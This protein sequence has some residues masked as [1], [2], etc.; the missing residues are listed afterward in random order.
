MNEMYIHEKYIEENLIEE[1]FKKAIEMADVNVEMK[2]N[3]EEPSKNIRIIYPCYSDKTKRISEQEIKQL[4]IQTLIEDQKLNEDSE[5]DFYFSVETPTEFKYKFSNSDGPRVYNEKTDRNNIRRF[6]SARFDLCMHQIEQKK[7]IRK[8]LLEFKATNQETNFQT[9]FLKLFIEKIE[10]K[11]SCNYFIHILDSADTGTLKEA[12]NKNEKSVIQK[13]Y[14]SWKYC[15]EYYDKSLKYFID[16]EE[17]NAIII[18]LLIIHNKTERKTSNDPAPSGYY[19]IVLGPTLPES[20]NDLQA[21]QAGKFR[22]YDL[23]EGKFLKPEN[24]SFSGPV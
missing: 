11:K 19:K 13:Y 14:E 6:K 2:K 1:A 15:I 5:K 12:E 24:D 18:Y 9:D 17:F 16:R 8:H 23:Q 4:F 20:P 3:K 7:F 10:E 21:V 22:I